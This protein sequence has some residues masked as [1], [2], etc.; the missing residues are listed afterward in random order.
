[1]TVNTE[2]VRYMESYFETDAVKK[3]RTLLRSA[4]LM[5]A[6]KPASMN[7]MAASLTGSMF[8]LSPIANLMSQ[9]ASSVL[10]VTK[11]TTMLNGV[12]AAPEAKTARGVEAKPPSRQLRSFQHSQNR[13]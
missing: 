7:V 2:M 4:G 9:G 1:M 5:I 8:I 10:W 3:R 12:S 11:P 13:L 6:A